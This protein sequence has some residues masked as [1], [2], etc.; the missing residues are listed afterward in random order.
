MV[1]PAPILSDA[2]QHALWRSHGDPPDA[3]GAA[4]PWRDSSFGSRSSWHGN[5][6]QQCVAID[7]DPAPAVVINRTGIGSID[8]ATAEKRIVA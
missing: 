3:T 1:V 5:G 8:Q 2:N 7:V 6:F 4:V